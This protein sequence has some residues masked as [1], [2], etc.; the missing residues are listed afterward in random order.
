MERPLGPLSQATIGTPRGSQPFR[1]WA[2][3]LAVPAG[4]SVLKDARGSSLVGARA[5]LAVSTHV[6]LPRTRAGDHRMSGSKPV[7]LLG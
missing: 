6:G 2:E 1:G 4:R 7:S 3:G 5:G